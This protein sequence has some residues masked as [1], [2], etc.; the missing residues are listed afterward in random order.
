MTEVHSD[1][2]GPERSAQ[3]PAASA[4]PGRASEKTAIFRFLAV[5][6][7]P[8]MSLLARYR[9]VDGEKMPKTGAF[10]LSPNHYSEIDPLVMGVVMWKL[11]RMPRFL[12]KSSLFSVPVLKWILKASGQIPVERSGSV[13]GSDPLALAGRVVERGLA[14][15][16]YPEGSLTRDPELW[17]MR[18]KTGAV[19]AAL[20]HGIPLIPIA[21]WGTQEVMPR[22]GKRISLF[23]RK[24][25]TVKVGDPVD[26]SAFRGARLD[27]AALAAATE[28]LMAAITALVA[29]LRG[30]QPPPERWDPSKHDQKEIGRFD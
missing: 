29:D 14:V 2:P 8:F 11:G 13:R 26:L 5:L 25:I 10:I 22:Y 17:P 30:E 3:R 16:I 20:A 15:I 1:G 19:R 28:S 9:I 7:L 12:A 21:H 18:G 27:T 4:G 24:T 6:I 23:P